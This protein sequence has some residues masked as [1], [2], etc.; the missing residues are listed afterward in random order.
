MLHVTN[1]GS[2]VAGLAEAGIFPAISWNDALHEGPVPAGIPAEDLCE[3]RAQFMAECGWDRQDTIA[4]DLRARDAA[5]LAASEVTLWFEHDLYD[6]L[7]LVQILAMLE[8]RRAWLAQAD[9]YIGPMQPEA[10][11]ALATAVKPVTPDQ[12]DIAGRAWGAFRSADPAAV[13]ELLRSDTSCLPYLHSAFARLLEDRPGSA[14]GLSRT[15]RQIL[16]AAATGPTSFGEL[17]AYTQAL[18]EAVFAGD[19][20]IM[21]AA[22]R[23]ADC[24]VPLLTMN[25]WRLTVAGQNV[26]DGAANHLQL[27]QVERWLGGMRFAS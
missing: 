8:G 14:D 9:T 10:V 22:K 20:Q 7:Q 17:Y 4:R 6:Q 16:R 2:A 1:G 23:I 11:R 26:L 25:P 24:D 15:E 18:E 3:V 21:L 19:T 12:L 27:N 5:L 13:P